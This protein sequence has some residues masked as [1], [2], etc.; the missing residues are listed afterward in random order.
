MNEYAED[1]CM[2]DF[3]PRCLWRRPSRKSKLATSSLLSGLEKPERKLVLRIM[4]AQGLIDR[5]T[6]RGQFPLRIPV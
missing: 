5:G 4:D 2:T 6:L 3:T 1:Y